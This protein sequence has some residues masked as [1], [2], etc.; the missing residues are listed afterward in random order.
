MGLP[1]ATLT[2]FKAFGSEMAVDHHVSPLIRIKSFN[3]R[4]RTFHREGITSSKGS[5][6]HPSPY[7]CPSEPD[8]FAKAPTR[9]L[10]PQILP[11][12]F[13][14]ALSS[15]HHSWGLNLGHSSTGVFFLSTWELLILHVGLSNKTAMQVSTHP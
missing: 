9:I 3:L 10:T 4:T 11:V 6:Y 14:G 12:C 7:R 2:D 15:K 1:C 8:R 5:S 13:Y